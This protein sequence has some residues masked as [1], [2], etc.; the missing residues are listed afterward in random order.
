MMEEVSLEGEERLSESLLKDD[1]VILFQEG[2]EEAEA[3]DDDLMEAAPELEDDSLRPEKAPSETVVEDI[4]ESVIEDLSPS[5]DRDTVIEAPSLEESE[6]VDEEP[7]TSVKDESPVVSE[8][9]KAEVISDNAPATNEA[10][11]AASVNKLGLV[12][13]LSTAPAPAPAPSPAGGAGEQLL[14]V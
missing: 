7:A 4:S 14:G 8:E 1:S 9:H 2:L 11:L 13:R 3:G 5:N 10:L 6:Y 12:S